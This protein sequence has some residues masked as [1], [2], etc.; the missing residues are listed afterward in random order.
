MGTAHATNERLTHRW[1]LGPIL[2]AAVLRVA[3]VFAQI[4]VAQGD[5]CEYL[6]IAERLLHA[7]QYQGLYEGPEVIY[8]PLPS[9]LIALVSALGMSLSTAGLLV[10]IASGV[11]LVVSVYFLGRH[12]YGPRVGFLSATLTAVSPP[13]IQLST[14]IH[15]ETLDIALVVGGIYFA[16]RWIDERRQG[17]GIACGALFSFAYLTRPEGILCL[18]VIAVAFVLTGRSHGSARR[19]T[20]SSVLPMLAI[21]GLIAAP[22]VAYLSHETGGF[23]IEGKSVVQHAQVRRL[24]AGMSLNEALY[25]LGPD[26]SEDG[27]MLSPNKWM[28]AAPASVR[29]GDRARELVPAARR[30]FNPLRWTLESGGFGGWLVIVLAAVGLLSRKR[31]NSRF[32][33]H[34]LV[35]VLVAGYAGV[36]LC[37]AAA[38]FFRYTI[39]ILP[40]MLIW[41]A[42][43]ADIAARWAPDTL[44]RSAMPRAFRGAA[45]MTAITGLLVA[46][47]LLLGLQAGYFRTDA[48]REWAR[49][50]AGCWLANTDSR[51]G[52]PIRVMSASNEVA[53]YAD[54]TKQRLPYASETKALAYLNAKNP[55]YVVL[56]N[57]PQF[58]A[59]Y[60]EWLKR[61][62]PDRAARLVHQI[63]PSNDPEAAVFEWTGVGEKR[64]SS[65]Q[66]DGNDDRPRGGA[67]MCAE[68]LAAYAKR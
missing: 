12:L 25:G 58:R 35:L 67:A 65:E 53:Y 27:P 40:F 47:V 52:Q 55:D 44:V 36:L 60:S 63:G 13:L 6:R 51:P 62:I 41:A 48:P 26:L 11:F 1:L 7:H 24:N 38:I 20:F 22:Y 14:T 10:G 15:S 33:S 16:V 32:A 42:S 23:R 66:A 49:M 19:Q 2:L 59:F 68:L 56:V 57:E 39:L 29:L 34:V 61:G 31:T 5:E 21:A 18:P 17:V 50:R 64:S 37:S 45:L 46:D 3:W 9:I 28:L 8:P 4:P 43:G 30:N 54:A